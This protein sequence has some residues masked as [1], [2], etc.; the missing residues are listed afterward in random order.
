[1]VDGGLVI[2]GAQKAPV[3]CEAWQV[4]TGGQLKTYD[5]RAWYDG[6]IHVGA[7]ASGGRGHFKLEGGDFVNICTA[8]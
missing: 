3:K 2:G 8:P 7:R 1:M 6:L 5:G 4:V